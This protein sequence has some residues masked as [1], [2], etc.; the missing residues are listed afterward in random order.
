MIGRD[1]G[2]DRRICLRRLFDHSENEVDV[3][4]AT[5]SGRLALCFRGNKLDRPHCH[6]GSKGL[7]H[8]N[9][10]GFM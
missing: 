4:K 2:R 1:E 10:V 5:R 9:G 7:S 8:R 6:N 3:N